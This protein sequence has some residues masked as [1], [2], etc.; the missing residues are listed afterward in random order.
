MGKTAEFVRRAHQKFLDYFGF[1]GSKSS[2]PTAQGRDTVPEAAEDFIKPL[3]FEFICATIIAL[4]AFALD[5]A[6]IHIMLV[7]WICIAAISVLLIDGLRRAKWA[8][9][10]GKGSRQFQAAVVAS[11]IVPVAF[12]IYLT[13]HRKIEEILATAEQMA[14]A[15]VEEDNKKTAVEIQCNTDSLPI[16]IASNDTGHLV[17]LDR[18]VVTGQPWGLFDVPNLTEKQVLWPD[19]KLLNESAK[20]HNPGVFTQRCVVSN[21]GHT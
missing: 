18:K 15:Q 21:E 16:H 4:F 10:R 7:S 3:S 13:A 20:K 11:I 14:H 12:G 17:L 6:D 8:S 2:L 19:K 1:K 9:I 5:Q